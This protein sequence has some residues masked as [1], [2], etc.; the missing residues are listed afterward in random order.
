[1]TTFVPSQGIRKKAPTFFSTA[2]RPTYA[3]IGRG[4]GRKLLLRGRKSWVSTPRCQRTSR[5]KPRAASS[6]CTL[7]VL[8]MQLWAAL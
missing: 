3:A 4:K 7:G 5:L 1:M 8:T 6:F 2:T